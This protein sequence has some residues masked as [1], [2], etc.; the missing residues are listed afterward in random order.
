MARAM[1]WRLA[2][3][4]SITLFLIPMATLF[5]EDAKRGFAKVF[6]RPGAK[7]H[8]NDGGASSGE[9]VVFFARG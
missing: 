5:V 9:L 3:A 8:Q 4:M 2:F 1:A 7:N 6:W